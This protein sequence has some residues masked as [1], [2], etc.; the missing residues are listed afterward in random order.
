M[1]QSSMEG[2]HE[3]HVHMVPTFKENIHHQH[4]Q[5]QGSCQVKG[6]LLSYIQDC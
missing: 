2:K 5:Q 6:A 3:E 1:P 4:R